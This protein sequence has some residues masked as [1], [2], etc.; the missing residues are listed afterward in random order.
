MIPEDVRLRAEYLSE[1]FDNA[2][3]RSEL[4]KLIEDYLKKH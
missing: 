2:S 3:C 4:R 1:H